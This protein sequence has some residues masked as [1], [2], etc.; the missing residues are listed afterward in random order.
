MVPH[1]DRSNCAKCKILLWLIHVGKATGSIASFKSPQCRV[2]IIVD[3]CN[4]GEQR[5]DIAD[6]HDG[7]IGRRTVAVF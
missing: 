2:A 5:D 4:L 3:G 7:A 1:K 6:E